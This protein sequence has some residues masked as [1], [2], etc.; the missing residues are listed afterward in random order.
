MLGVAGHDED[1]GGEHN[2]DGTEDVARSNVLDVEGSGPIGLG[3]DRGPDGELLLLHG[4]RETPI[5]SRLHPGTQGRCPYFILV[6]SSS[7]SV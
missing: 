6:L 3:M 5:S 7:Y 4:A 1:E 2:P